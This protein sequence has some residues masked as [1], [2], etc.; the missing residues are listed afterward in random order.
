MARSQA[1][2]FPRQRREANSRTEQPATRR[3]PPGNASKSL[4]L[5]VPGER[6]ELPTNGLQ[7]RCSTA[8]L[9]RPFDDLAFFWHQLGTDLCPP[10]ASGVD[11]QARRRNRDGLLLELGWP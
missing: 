11:S 4:A 9:T 8:E 3:R 10:R 7:N 5:M 2:P 6:I 1:Q